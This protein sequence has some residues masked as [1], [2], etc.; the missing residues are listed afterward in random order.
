MCYIIVMKQIRLILLFFSFL[1]A[2]NSSLLARNRDEVRDYDR[3]RLL[4]QATGTPVSGSNSFEARVNTMLNPESQASP[5]YD[6][7]ARTEFADA[8]DL[9]EKSRID[10]AQNMKNLARNRTAEFGYLPKNDTGLAAVNLASELKVP[11]VKDDYAEKNSFVDASEE[12]FQKNLQTNLREQ[13]KEPENKTVPAAKK[14][15]TDTPGSLPSLANNPFYFAGNSEQRN[16]EENFE[17]SK[18][19]ILTRM[20]QGGMSVD[21][22]EQ[23]LTASTSSEDVILKLMQDFGKS[24]SSAKDTVSTK[25]S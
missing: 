15:K 2:A 4:Q 22:A 7:Q 13:A 24:Y 6:S 12:S 20:V 17:V 8:E 5:V 23:I 9:R 16:N 25:K 10:A 21:E 18:P 11:A 3:L 14:N 19:L 1:L